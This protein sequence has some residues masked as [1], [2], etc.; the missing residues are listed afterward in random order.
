M[1]NVG[2]TTK[3]LYALSS[4]SDERAFLLGEE[5]VMVRHM[6]RHQARGEQNR[7]LTTGGA[8][9]CAVERHHKP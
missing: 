2:G 4:Q 6:P 1:R 8:T 5:R 7:R 3:R 9:T